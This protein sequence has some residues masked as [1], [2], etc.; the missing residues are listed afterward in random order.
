ML[1]TPVVFYTMTEERI[2]D[3]VGVRPAVLRQ[4]DHYQRSQPKWL[5][6]AN[7]DGIYYINK[8]CIVDV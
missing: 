5:R 6:D 1:M 2:S 3:G 7:T 4:C 8:S